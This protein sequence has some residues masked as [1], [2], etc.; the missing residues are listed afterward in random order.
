MWTWNKSYK[1][2]S[3]E[4]EEKKLLHTRIAICPTIQL[5]N[6]QIEWKA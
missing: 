2:F 3:N 6:K 1:T 5:S 4:E